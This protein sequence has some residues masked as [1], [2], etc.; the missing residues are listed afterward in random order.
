MTHRNLPGGAIV[1]SEVADSLAI[2]KPHP[3]IWRN[4]GKCTAN[5]V[6]T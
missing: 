1:M 3:D 5:A 6:R 4:L 2:A